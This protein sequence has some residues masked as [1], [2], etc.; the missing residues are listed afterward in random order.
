MIQPMST[1][2]AIV[3]LA[4]GSDAYATWAPLDV[5]RKILSACFIDGLIP[6]VDNTAVGECRM[7]EGY[8]LSD[9]LRH[10]ADNMQNG[11]MRLVVDMSAL[12]PLAEGFQTT[13]DEICRDVKT[14]LGVLQPTSAAISDVIIVVHNVQEFI[15]TVYFS[16]SLKAACIAHNIGLI[17]LSPDSGIAT[18]ENRSHRIHQDVELRLGDLHRPAVQTRVATNT[19]GEI[20]ASIIPIYGHFAVKTPIIVQ[21][22]RVF[23]RHLTGLILLPKPDASDAYIGYLQKIFQEKLGCNDFLIQPIGI[24]VDSLSTLCYEIVGDDQHRFGLRN[25]DISGKCVA[26]LCDMLCEAYAIDS[27]VDK[28]KELGARSVFT[29]AFSTINGYK[30]KAPSISFCELPFREYEESNC[31]NCKYDDP[32]ISSDA[33]DASS[34]ED[35]IRKIGDFSPYSFWNLVGLTPRAFDGQHWP[36]PTTGYHYIHRII[37]APLFAVHG[38]SIACRIRNLLLNRIRLGWIDGF[39]CPDGEEAVELAHMLA[40]VMGRSE[41]QVVQVPRRFFKS[42]TGT[43]VPKELKAGFADEYE[44]KERIDVRVLRVDVLKKRVALALDDQADQ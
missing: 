44:F 21:N 34:I 26:L 27:I 31:T 40:R 42:I 1:S 32:L 18:V 3:R 30:S 17:V 33:S 24:N 6:D 39:V 43:S 28:C 2:L 12:S 9:H 14:S 23:M 20:K 16:R 7:R 15:K 37:C 5:Y 22:Q 36:S 10:I 35:Y 19:E 25:S 38:Y 4:F 41:K 11:G 8:D 29:L 13:C